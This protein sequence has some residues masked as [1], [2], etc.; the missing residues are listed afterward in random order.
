MKCLVFG[1]QGQVA[2][3]LAACASPEFEIITLGRPVGDITDLDKVN[4][5]MDAYNPD[6]VINAAAYTAVDKAEE[7]RDLAFAV[8]A[9]GPENLARACAGRDIPLIHYSTDY[10]FDGSGDAPWAPDQPTNPLGVY[11][12]SKLE[13]EQR[14][15]RV[16]AKHVILRTAWVYSPYGNNFVKTMLRL[17]KDRDALNVVD[18]Q[19]GNPT[20]A[21]DIA[22]A[23]LSVAN[24]I[25]SGKPKYGVYHL[26]N[27]GETS[28]CGFAKAIFENA[29]PV[30]GVECDV[31]AIPSSAYPT[32]A[33]RPKNSRLDCESLQKDYGIFMSH[34][35]DALKCCINTIASH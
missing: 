35:S 32:P 22:L 33:K 26:T 19:F 8:N 6:I 14:L 21:P 30:L 17:G 34:W 27:R 28:W 24:Q 11:G 16:H 9:I 13:G 5:A 20:Y 15:A 18:D 23:S 12:K 4:A 7:E 31:S 2:L 3:S 1:G 29:E 10:V 25:L